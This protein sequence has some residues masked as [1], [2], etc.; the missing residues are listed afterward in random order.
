M[1]GIA[2]VRP[3]RTTA[4]GA[5]LALLSTAVFSTG[6]LA[7]S[8]PTS[9]PADPSAPATG[10]ASSTAEPDRTATGTEPSRS[11]EPEGPAAPAADADSPPSVP[12]D[13]GEIVA[14]ADPVPGEYIV[15]LADVSPFGV[16]ATAAAL[17][18]DHGGEVLRTYRHALLG[19]AVEMS[20]AQALELSKDPRVA[21]VEENGVVRVDVTQSGA[22]WGLDRIDQRDL[23]LSTTYTYNATGSGVDAYII[24]TGVRIT[25]QEFGGRA[26]SGFDFID[27]DADASDCNGHGTHVAGTVGGSTFGVAKQVNLVA[28]RVLDCGGSGSNAGVIAGI[29]WVTANH[30]GPSVANMSLGGGASATLDAAVTNSIASGVVYALAAGNDNGANACNGSPGRTPNALTV[31][32]TTSTD[33]RSSFS[34]IGTCLDIF[35]PGS[36]ITSAWLTNDTATNTIS[37]T[38]MAT[39]HVAGAAALYLQTRPT[40]TPAEVGAALVAQ[41]TANKVTDPGTGSPNRLL[42]TGDIVLGA[43]IT[44]IQDSVADSPQDFAFAVT[45]PTGACA[46]FS[47]DDDADAT[48]PRSVNGT[49][50]PTGTYTITQAAVPGWTLTGLTCDTGETVDLPNRR[51]TISLTTNEQVT[52]TFT[53]RSPSITIVQDATPNSA[54]DFAFTGCQGVG[55]SA[56]SLDDDN[57]ATLANRVT[58]AGLAPGTYVVTQTAVPNWSLTSL[59]CDTGEVI[60]LANRRATIT[61]GATEHA[62]C[63]W[64]NASASIAIVQDSVPDEAQ[65]YS[66]TGCLGAGCSTW[67]M[68]D[69]NVATLP[70]SVQGDGLAAGVYTIT[71]GAVAARDLFA[72]SCTT[73]ETIDLA[74]RRATIT[75]AAGE[76]VTCTFSNRPTGANDNFASAEAIAGTSGSV[77]GTTVNATKETGEPNHGGNSGGRS[78]WFS[79]TAPSSG[80]RT[81]S[82]CGGATWDTTLGVYTGSAVDALATVVTNDDGCSLQSS[83]TFNA[84]AGTTYRIAID[85]YNTANGTFTLSWS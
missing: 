19:F 36:A 24:D 1:M 13:A 46:A 62:T 22:T 3:V 53:D 33:A 75:L 70:R 18:A 15:T 16:G 65:D 11:D 71:Q 6:A 7:Q 14:A 21:T 64:S 74:N 79:W 31:G 72:L 85:G 48:L 8:T 39:P 81:F 17:A 80:S 44:L 20:E 27:N 29:D 51:V 42:Y 59:V 45:C 50:I 12:D 56:F 68:D 63:T 25:H 40:S 84:T 66:F 73:G 32:S 28:V 61:L 34:N 41:S 76:Q 23:P 60:D 2:I 67:S 4:L 30:S 37:G 49:A 82:T 47:M 35:A 38:S 57:N 83:V 54:Q 26:T 78:V 9:A 52:C 58:G 77:A 55:C 5:M 10:A 43:S 69:D